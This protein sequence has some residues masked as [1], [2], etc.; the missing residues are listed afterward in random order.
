MLPILTGR[1]WGGGDGGQG[2]EEG[3]KE[4]KQDCGLVSRKRQPGLTASPLLA[5]G[6]PFPRPGHC[7]E[8]PPWEHEREPLKRVYHFIL[9]QTVHYQC[10]QGFRALQTGP[11]ESTCTLINGEIKWTRPRLKCISEGANGQVPGTEVPP[12]PRVHHLVASLR[13]TRLESLIHPLSGLG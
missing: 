4:K 8:P 9:G 10:A 2:K 1:K 3:A 6:I 5:S 12:H 11:A 7:K 13:W